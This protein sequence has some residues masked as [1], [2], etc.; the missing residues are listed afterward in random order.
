MGLLEA[1]ILGVVEGA[2]EFLPISSTGHMILVAKLMGLEQGPFL[3]SFEIAIQLGS[4]LAIL[5]LYWERVVRD[6]A[7]WKRILA[8]FVPT[9]ILGLLL[10]HFIKA[11][12]A[13][14]VVAI[15]LIVGGL[16]FILIELFYL[17]RNPP[18]ITKLDGIGYK[19]AVI[20]GLFQ[21]LAMIPGTSRSG[22]TIIGGLLLG[23]ERKVATE[24]SFLLAIPTLASAAGYDLLKHYQEFRG[25]D[26][27]LLGV[28]F[29]TA[30]VVALGVVRWFL[31]F[32]KG[33]TFIPFGIYRIV[34]GG[35]FLLLL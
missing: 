28:G 6:I 11:L 17:P 21:S 7:L 31:G 27:V 35:L 25:E 14:L 13:P 22:A 30:F 1:F 33:H 9:A 10:Y 15:M 32:L 2:S 29:I 26:I 19:E 23:M 3:K 4:I 8:A 18:T 34:V 5:L 20:V 24:F 16:L 12:F